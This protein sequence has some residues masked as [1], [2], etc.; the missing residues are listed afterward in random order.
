MTNEQEDRSPRHTTRTRQKQWRVTHLSTDR[1]V[2]QVI[3]PLS[4]VKQA[5]RNA[6]SLGISKAAYVAAALSLAA[7]Q[8]DSIL[9]R[10]RIL[11]RVHGLRFRTAGSSSQYT[12][13]SPAHDE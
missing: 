13:G 8:K 3:E 1:A 11:T 12:P 5:E 10:I 4:L 9:T 6:A 7:E 2:L